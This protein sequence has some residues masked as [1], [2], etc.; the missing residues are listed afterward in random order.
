M[1]HPL[2]LAL[3]DDVAAA[4]RAA[5]VVHALGIRGDR[6]SVVAASHEQEGQI[7]RSIDATPGAEIEDSRVAARLGELS[8]R[9]IAAV[10][11]VLPGVGPIVAG[12]PLAAEFG[13]AVGH[14]A[15]DIAAVLRRAGVEASVASAWQ[16]RIGSG[17]VLLGVHVLD[18]DAEPV[19][20]ALARSGAR[21]VA[22]ARWA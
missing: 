2:V 20:A 15:G 14:V 8:A 7:A 11:G 9:V 17:A 18:G 21:E 1:S 3:F 5:A 13:E 6:L 4:S 19:R 10:A 22:L 12:G 16:S